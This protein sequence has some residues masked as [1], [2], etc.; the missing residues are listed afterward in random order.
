ME[1]VLA[2]WREVLLWCSRAGVPGTDSEGLFSHEEHLTCFSWEG[3]FCFLSLYVESSLQSGT[4]CLLSKS[5][6]FL[7]LEQDRVM[8][9]WVIRAQYR[10][11]NLGHHEEQDL[12]AFIRKMRQFRALWNCWVSW[13]PWPLLV[14]C[15]FHCLE[16]S[17]VLVPLFRYRKWVVSPLIGIRC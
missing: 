10:F 13:L 2:V 12:E 17:W 6:G 16:M 15:D 3:L 9:R 11:S 1:G 4:C 8:A 7:S 14:L 5:L